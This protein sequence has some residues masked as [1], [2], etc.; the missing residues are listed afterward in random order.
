M[1]EDDFSDHLSLPNPNVDYGSDTNT[2]RDIHTQNKRGQNK[3]I[4]NPPW[5]FCLQNF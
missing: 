5:L 2:L 1:R 3:K 4:K